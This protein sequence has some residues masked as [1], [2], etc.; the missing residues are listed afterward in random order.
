[1]S[2][3]GSSALPLAVRRT[4]VLQERLDGVVGGWDNYG[5]IKGANDLG[6]TNLAALLGCQHYGDAAVERFAAFAGEDVEHLG[7]GNALEYGSE[8]GDA[9]LGHMREDQVMQ[10]VLRFARGGSGAVVFAHTSAL[11]SDLPVVGRGEV[12]RTWSEGAKAVAEELRKV[13][14]E[15]VTAGGVA[16]GLDLSTKHVRRLLNEFANAGYVEKR[17]TGEGLANG[18]ASAKDP[19]AGEVEINAE[20]DAETLRTPDERGSS[21]Y[22]TVNVRVPGLNDPDLPSKRSRKANLPAPNARDAALVEGDPPE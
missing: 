10:A 4:D 18:Y 17:E 14:D 19:G 20:V 7:R 8:V 21:I 1:M 16:E 11:R 5:N 22:Y 15:E 13:R 2:Q 6:D 12:M 9:F 3:R